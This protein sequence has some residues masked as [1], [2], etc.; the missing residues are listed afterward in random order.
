MFQPKH[1][2]SKSAENKSC[3][4]TCIDEKDFSQINTFEIMQMYFKN[5][6]FLLK[7]SNSVCIKLADL[8]IRHRHPLWSAAELHVEADQRKQKLTM[9]SVQDISTGALLHFSALA[10][11][12]TLKK[13]KQTQRQ[14]IFPGLQGRTADWNQPEIPEQRSR[15]GLALF[16][17]GRLKKAREERLKAAPLTAQRRP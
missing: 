6:N 11:W 8:P 4:K 5:V 1:L 13:S 15:L 7:A 12:M 17:P 10:A 3:R 9:L 16:P 14:D 2:K